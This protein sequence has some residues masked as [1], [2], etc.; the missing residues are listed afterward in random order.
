MAAT[1][2]TTASTSHVFRLAAA[3][4]ATVVE[5]LGTFGSSADEHWSPIPM[6]K[7]EDG[8]FEAT[9]D[10]LLPGT[11]YFY[12]FKVD[13]EWVV[14]PKAETAVDEAGITN[15]VFTPAVVIEPVDA[16]LPEVHKSADSAPLPPVNASEE[17]PSADVNSEVASPAADI[18]EPQAGQ[19]AA[20]PD[21]EPAD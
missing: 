4:D 21:S 2:P 13:G 9:V 20:V 12:K 7:G 10:G 5:L 6:T 18:E 15:N 17:K 8:K 1:I 11:L 19:D 14:D 16:L 3:D